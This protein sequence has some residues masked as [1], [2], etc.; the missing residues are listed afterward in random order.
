MSNKVMKPAKDVAIIGY[1]A[2]IPRYRIKNEEI[3]RVWKN[4]QLFEKSN[5][6]GGP[7]KQKAVAARDEDAITMA[8]EA[9]RRAIR[10][11]GIDPREIRAIFL[12]TESNPYAVKTAGVTIAA[13]I[14][15]PTDI[16]AATYE[17]ACKAGTEAIQTS[18]GLI[19]SGM[20]KYTLAI[21][22][23]TAQGRPMD[24]LEYTAASGAVA[25]IL[26]EYMRGDSIAKVEASYSY[27]KDVPD[28]WRRE[29]SPYPSHFQRFTGEPAYFD[30][31]MNAAKNLMESLNY[32]PKDFDYAVFHQPNYKFP[33]KVAKMLGFRDEQ[34]KPG[35]LSYIIGNTYSGSSLMGLAATLDVAKPGDRILIVS[36]GSGSGSDAISLIVD[37]GIEKKRDL[38]PKVMDLINNGVKEIDYALYA[39]FRRKIIR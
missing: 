16:L 8:I 28:F 10:R 23:D 5:N 9:A 27:A 14:G 7:I 32:T 24:A 2:Y 26:G 39:R 1:G 18:I 11:A 13:A 12:G 19:G 29:L 6:V 34:I 21:G 30:L 3:A 20:V 37:E 36:Y 15:G 22:A 38:A 35:L 25:Y 31:I 33:V 4:G 17:F